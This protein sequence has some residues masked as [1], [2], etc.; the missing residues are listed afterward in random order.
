MKEKNIAIFKSDVISNGGYL[1]SNTDR[2]SS[3]LSCRRSTK[4]IHQTLG[5]LKKKKIIDIGCGDG[6]FTKK[7]IALNPEFVTG[8]DPNEAA[9][10][11][12]K[13]NTS[14]IKNINF[15]VMDIYE[16]PLIQRYDIAIIRGVL[17]HLYQVEKAI[18]LIC[19]IANEIIVLEPNGYNPILKI[20]EKTS[21]Y[22]ILHEEKSYSPRKLDQWFRNNGGDI[23]KSMYVG[24]VPMF[25]PDF[26]AKILNFLEPYLEKTPLIRNFSCGQYIQK[27]KIKN[28]TNS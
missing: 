21:P 4:A 7:L 23:T 6:I 11:I 15:Q 8:V 14:N 12:A 18:E 25:C 5:C 1:Y 27:I 16:I 10:A 2:L 26:L 3:R 24:F 17:H 13:K 9:I 20:I 28:L 19:K 22:H